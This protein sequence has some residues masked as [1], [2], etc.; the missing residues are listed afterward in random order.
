MD[1]SLVVPSFKQADT[2]ASDLRNLITFLDSLYCEYEIIVVI[3]G[4][5]DNT[6][7]VIQHD[8]LLRHVVVEVLPKNQGKGFAVRNGFLQAQGAI[9]GFV[10]AGSDIDYEC[11]RLMIDIMRF[12]HADIVIGSKRHQLSEVQ[13]PFIRRIYSL[14]YQILYQGLFK[15][16]V[17]DTQVG[18]KLFRKD[19][20]D[21]VLPHL[22]IKRF[23]FDLELLVVACELG[24]A[25]IIESP[26]RIQHT[27]HS[28]V[29]LSVVF[30]MLRD[31]IGLFV[32]R[33]LKQSPDISP[34]MSIVFPEQHSSSEEHKRVREHVR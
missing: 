29:N 13:Y 20:I 3:D 31:T 4:D 11:I 21:A 14:G 2:I 28:T 9:V 22:K 27:F 33:L 8:P 23:A 19:V 25:N 12:S 10:D 17:R 26:V 34:A 32:R 7:Q 16:A 18:L 24:Y 15:I 5:I 1:L 6:A 30:E